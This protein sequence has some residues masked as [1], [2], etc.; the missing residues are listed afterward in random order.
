MSVW[1]C[2]V[3]VV[4]LCGVPR[5]SA[6]RSHRPRV[7]TCALGPGGRIDGSARG[8]PVPRSLPGC[9]VALSARRVMLMWRSAGAGVGAGQ[10]SGRVWDTR[11]RTGVGGVPERDKTTPGGLPKARTLFYHLR[12]AGA[13]IK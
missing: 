4:W 8:L 10:R 12:N 1:L 6:G 3:C 13:S 9:R 11:H 7:V 2:R 5:V